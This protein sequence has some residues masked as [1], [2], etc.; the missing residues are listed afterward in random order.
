MTFLFILQQSYQII[1][2][3]ALIFNDCN[4]IVDSYCAQLFTLK[5]IYKSEEYDWIEYR[6]WSQKPGFESV[7]CHL[8]SQYVW[9]N[10]SLIIHLVMS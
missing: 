10:Y 2:H 1:W 7:L 4:K 5:Q 8:L 3:N 9:Q 6:L